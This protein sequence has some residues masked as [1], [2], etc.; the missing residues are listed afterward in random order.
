MA[1]R[2]HTLR[3]AAAVFRT[4]I[5]FPRRL[6][7]DNT[8]NTQTLRFKDGSDQYGF[9]NFI[10]AGYTSGGF[11]VDIWW[12]SAGTGTSGNVLWA[13]SF[14]AAGPTDNVDFTTKGLDT[15]N[16]FADAHQGSTAKRPHLATFNVTD[17][18]AAADGDLVSV[19]LGRLGANASDTYNS[20]DVDFLLAQIRYD[21]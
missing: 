9:W 20:N 10:V 3:P 18:N 15:Q 6:K 12:V 1:Q 21:I 4:A 16:T 19:R 14:N 7:I 11:D 2:V 13:A 5:G 8:V 17:L